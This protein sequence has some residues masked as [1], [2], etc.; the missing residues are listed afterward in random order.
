MGACAGYLR[1][2]IHLEYAGIRLHRY[3]RMVENYGSVDTCM[4]EDIDKHSEIH[5]TT[6]PN[7][8]RKRTRPS[9]AV[10]PSRAARLESARG[11]D[12]ALYR[13][14]LELVARLEDRGVHLLH[15]VPELDAEA[16]ED[17]ALPRVVLGVHARLHLLVVDDADPKGLLR[18]GRVERRARLLDL[19]EKLLPVRERVAEPVE[20]VFGLEVPER[21]E[22]EPLG[23][24]VFERLDLRLD[25]RERLLE[26]CVGESCK[27][28]AMSVVEVSL[29]RNMTR[30]RDVYVTSVAVCPCI[31]NPISYRELCIRFSRHTVP[32]RANQTRYAGGSTCTHT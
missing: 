10:Q 9:P 8:S 28:C 7:P 6:P 20:D 26:G 2:N 5:A 18:L 1:L 16:G 11:A 22:L 15:R 12:E 30:T 17:V 32:A 3:K 25:E 21:L 19:C 31:C 4:E 27:L 14:V 13:V 23:N 29:W 24:V